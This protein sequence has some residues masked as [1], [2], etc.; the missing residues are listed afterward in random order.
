MVRPAP[1][2]CQKVNMLLEIGAQLAKG[3]SVDEAAITRL[4]NRM[5][6]LTTT[7]PATYLIELMGPYFYQYR[8]KIIQRDEH[9]FMRGGF[10]DEVEL[11]A[12]ERRETVEHFTRILANM[13]NMA[14]ESERNKV[15]RLCSGM[16]ANYIDYLAPPKN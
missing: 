14:D 2:F 7:Q 12:G 11:P 15:Y 6:I 10:L 5:I 13:Y 3:R 16:L 1:A 4:Q 9:F 8:A